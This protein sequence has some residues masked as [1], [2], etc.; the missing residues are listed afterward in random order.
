MIQ[1]IPSKFNFDR[2][3]ALPMETRINMEGKDSAEQGVSVEWIAEQLGVKATAISSPSPNP[4]RG[5]LQSTGWAWGEGGYK[6]F[7]RKDRPA[8]KVG[9]LWRF[10]LTEID[11]WVRS[12]EA[13]KDA[14]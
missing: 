4:S 7:E 10:K 8:R 2:F 5:F 1:F 13:K 12:G 14:E 6:W 9:R 11:E 3:D